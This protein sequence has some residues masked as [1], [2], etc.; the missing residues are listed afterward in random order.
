[1]KRM[2]AVPC[3]VALLLVAC[4]GDTTEPPPASLAGV[5]EAQCDCPPY[6]GPISMTL[7]H[8][9]GS[10]SLTGNGAWGGIWGQL[11]LTVTGTVTL[12]NVSLTLSASAGPFS[13]GNLTC[14][15][16]VTGKEMSCTLRGPGFTPVL[17]RFIRR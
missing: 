17:I 11:T 15:G 1:M 16:T 14:I 9:T 13:A 3:A 4:G 2:L 7:G 5:W 6:T 8:N 10:N 12:P